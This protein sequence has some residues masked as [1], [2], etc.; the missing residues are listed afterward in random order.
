[1]LMM[2]VRVDV[3]GPPTS[4]GKGN[5]KSCHKH[6]DDATRETKDTLLKNDTTLLL[7]SLLFKPSAPQN[8]I[9]TSSH[10]PSSHYKLI[11]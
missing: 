5:G 10:F 8:F 6:E 7:D 9:I 1:M 3:F 4:H 2:S 11:V